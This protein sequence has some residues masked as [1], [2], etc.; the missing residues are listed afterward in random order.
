MQLDF[1]QL[2]VNQ[3][4]DKLGKGGH[5][6]GSGS[7]A[8]LQ[9]MISSKLVQTVIIISNRK[10]YQEIYKAVLPKL[11]QMS[12]E[13][14]DDIFPRLAD[15][16]H[17]DAFYFDKAIQARIATSKAE[18]N[19]DFYEVARL[20]KLEAQELK[21]SVKIPLQIGELCAKLAKISLFVFQNAF[22]SARGDSHVALG[23]AVA[24]LAGCLSIVQL[25][26]LSF[27]IGHYYWTKEMNVW[28]DDLKREYEIL[29]GEVDNCVAILES[30]VAGRMS[31]YSDVNSFLKKSKFDGF[32]K[33]SEIEKLAAEFQNLLWINRKLLDL[34]TGNIDKIGVFWTKK[35]KNKL[36]FYL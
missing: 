3:L 2:T 12:Q 21:M 14:D 18:S 10:K 22:K 28:Y 16:F 26:F 6:P 34:Q 23:G 9:G 30:E 7:A 4:L 20:S 15:A 5:K 1:S 32:R 29:K 33:D 11:L 27:K 13:I 31:L 35:H 25:N 19:L 8:A 17:Q 24:S 36:T